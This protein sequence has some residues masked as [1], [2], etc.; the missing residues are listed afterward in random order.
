MSRLIVLEG[1]D[2][3]GK[4]TLAES[5]A[6]EFN[7]TIHN[8]PS[9]GNSVSFLRDIT[10][11]TKGFSAFERQCL[12]SMS[13]IV[14]FYEEFMYSDKNYIL[15]RC[16]LSTFVYG[17]A[18]GAS[19]DKMSVLMDVH[20]K[21]AASILNN[22]QVDIFVLDR[23]KRFGKADDSHHE[24]NIKWNSLRLI[25]KQYCNWPVEKFHLFSKEEKRH[26]I[27]VG[28]RTSEEVF[29]EV[30][31]KLVNGDGTKS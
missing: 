28:D 5:L 26:L 3:L 14:D 8:S 30:M 23:D 9:R 1:P 21:I 2:G 20:R 31:T 12:H 18:E 13:N 7:A 27:E 22:R 25:Y 19:L 29:N 24:K 15:D 4:T 6:K 10:R 11:H 16:H 17:G